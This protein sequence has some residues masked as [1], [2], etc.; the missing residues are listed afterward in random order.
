MM[1]EDEAEEALADVDFS[2]CYELQEW[3]RNYARALIHEV[4]I[5]REDV[6]GG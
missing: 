6:D 5:C 4:R 2:S 3:M 1:I